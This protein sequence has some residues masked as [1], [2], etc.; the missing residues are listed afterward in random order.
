MAGNDGR[1]DPLS[2]MQGQMA[3][4]GRASVAEAQA[5]LARTQARLAGEQTD[6]TLMAL[7]FMKK[8][9]DAW[10]A[11]F[12]RE[13]ATRRGHQQ[14]RMA[15]QALIQKLA[16]VDRAGAQKLIDQAY[17][18]NKA[19][20]EASITKVDEWNFTGIEPGKS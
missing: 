14:S 1:I 18:E 19:A 6:Q 5:G 9:V 8:Q 10:R 7:G 4:N 15:A 11:R 3:A 17:A 16:N 2:Y 20:I 13:R 12:E